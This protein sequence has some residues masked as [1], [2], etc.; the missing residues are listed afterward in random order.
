[1]CDTWTL[2]DT[3]HII[4]ITTAF[5]T[6]NAIMPISQLKYLLDAEAFP[7]MASYRILHFT[8]S[9]SGAQQNVNHQKKHVKYFIDEQKPY[10]WKSL[11]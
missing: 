6:Q 5:I 10:K 4:S 1:M 8:P 9:G 7:N 2:D 11:Y 3:K